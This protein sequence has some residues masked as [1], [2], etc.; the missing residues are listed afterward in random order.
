MDGT[1]LM[2]IA[3]GMMK[4]YGSGV[5]E[6]ARAKREAA[7]EALREQRADA[8]AEREMKFRSDE[9]AIGRQFQADENEKERA[10]R[11]EYGTGADGSSL[12]IQGGTAKP[13]TDDK[14]KPVKLAKTKDASPAEVQTAE[15]LIQQGVAPDAKSAWELV[16]RA[17]DDPEKSKAGIYKAWLDTLT[18]GQIGADPQKI[19]D[20]ARQRTEE[21]MRFLDG[22]ETGSTGQT[23][24][25]APRDP[26][27]RTVG[28]TYSA[29]DGR[30]VKWTG[31]GWELV[32]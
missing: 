25:P 29:P 8:R 17:R 15:W 20:E 21:T 4:G 3:G 10:S 23:L 2:A 6:A 26:K 27:Q 18:E 30:K 19:A 5:L 13:V 24:M 12:F 16:R 9:A 32:E 14:G 28:T 22:E 31:E 11:G 1:G 7:L